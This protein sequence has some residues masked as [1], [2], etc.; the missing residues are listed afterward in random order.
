MGSESF[1][2]ASQVTP[3]GY[4]IDEVT[5][6]MQKDDPPR[7]RV[8][9]LHW[10]TELARP[11]TRTTSGSGCGSSPAKTSASASR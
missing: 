3:G 4:R 9:A 10:A 1:R 7:Q 11:A 8:D 5:S 2:F 6:A